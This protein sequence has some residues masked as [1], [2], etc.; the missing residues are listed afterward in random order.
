[1]TGEPL[2]AQPARAQPM[3]DRVARP[4]IAHGGAAADGL[5]QHQLQLLLPARPQQQARHGAVDGDAPVQRGLR[6]GLVLVRDHRAVARRRA[7]GRTHLLL[8][9]G[10][11]HH[12]AAAP[13]VGERKA[14]LPDQR[15]PGERR[16]VPAVPGMERRHRRQHR[17]P[18]RDPR[19]QPQD[20]QRQGHLRQDG[21]GHPLPAEERR[22]VPRAVGAVERQ[23]GRPRRDAR[24]LHRREHRQGLLQRRGIGRHLRLRAVRHARVPSCARASPPSCAASGTRRA[25]AAR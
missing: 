8:P 19:P 2:C 7:D 9:R 13:L 5:L 12:R 6:L 4:E 22:A 21:G 3:P 16:L 1:M 24:L 23:P 10:L 25:R 18:A 20:A 11:R 17:R 15:H 14:L